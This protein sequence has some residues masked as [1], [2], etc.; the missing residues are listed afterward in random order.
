[1]KEIDDNKNRLNELNQNIRHSTSELYELRNSI[2]KIKIEHEDHRV[3]INKLASVKTR[4]EEDINRNKLVF[5]KYASIKEKI[6]QEQE[7]IKKKREITASL[8]S[9]NKISAGEKTFESRNPKW[10]K[11]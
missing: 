11:L 4:L 8:K 6:R 9:S 2:N 3:S 1:N 10:F 5:D 7:L